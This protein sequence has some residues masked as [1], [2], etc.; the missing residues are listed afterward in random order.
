MEKKQIMVFNLTGVMVNY[1]VLVLLLQNPI[2]IYFN[3]IQ[4]QI[5]DTV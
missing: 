5:V 4:M 3:F 2:A 1:D